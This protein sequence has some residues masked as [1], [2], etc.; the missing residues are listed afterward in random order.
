MVIQNLDGSPFSSA[1]AFA[2][3]PKPD[4]R[5]TRGDTGASKDI[6]IVGSDHGP[7]FYDIFSSTTSDG[8]A[9]SGGDPYGWMW[10]KDLRKGRVYGNVASSTS[11]SWAW[12]G[13]SQT[14]CRVTTSTEA[15]G[16][17]YDRIVEHKLS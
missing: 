6:T 10:T 8:F 17:F 1:D 4:I 16:Q 11:Y 3:G 9:V 5:V 13:R 2:V 7:L 12:Y 14:S 15:S